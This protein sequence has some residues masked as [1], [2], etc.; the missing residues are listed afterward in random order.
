MWSKALLHGHL[1]VNKES[2]LL[3]NEH[4]L[5]LSPDD[6]KEVARAA[7]K[8]LKALLEKLFELYDIKSAFDINLAFSGNDVAVECFHPDAALSFNETLN[9]DVPTV[10]IQDIP[11]HHRVAIEQEPVGPMV[12]V[13]TGVSCLNIFLLTFSG[14]STSMM[15]NMKRLAGLVRGRY[16]CTLP[17]G[18]GKSVVFQL[19]SILQPGLM[20]VVSPLLALINDQ[21]D[22][23]RG[24]GIDRVISLTSEKSGKEQGLALDDLKKAQFLFG[25]VA[26]ERFQNENFLKTILDLKD[27]RQFPLIAV[28]E[29][30][31]L[32]EWG[33][34]FRPAY[35]NIGQISREQCK[36][37]AFT[38]PVLA[39][40]GTASPSVLGDIRRELGIL[41][42]DA[43]IT[44]A[45]F[46]RPNINFQL[47][48][49]PMGNKEHALNEIIK[50]LPGNLV[51]IMKNPSFNSRARKRTRVLF[52]AHMLMEN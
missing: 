22:N 42:F 31:C 46:D 30:H 23:L 28:D 34:D 47:N 50:L 41:D 32:S 27:S 2:S 40:T 38:P 35:L 19:T 29:V 12:A 20:I 52:F 33:H 36:V 8:D 18:A 5:L 39:L 17:T 15:A 44:P 25:Y 9:T 24:S 13:N 48:S 3:I 37:G 43:L 51:L 11:F 16:H 14:T 4:G 21:L 6:S 1:P 10:Y 49:C 45:T 26:P 7:I